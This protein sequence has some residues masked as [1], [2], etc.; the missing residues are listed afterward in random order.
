MTQVAV[1]GSL[2]RGMGNNYLLDQ[3]QFVGTTQTQEAYAMYSLGGFPKVVLG[4]SICP[5]IVEVYDV[6]DRGLARLD[7]LEG[8]RGNA[9]DS[10]YNRTEVPVVGLGTALIYHIENETVRRSLDVV[11]DGDWVRFLSER[12]E[13]KGY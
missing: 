10:F 11:E 12:R 1:Y 6:D 8:Y 5:I 2:R 3:Q 7:Q 9:A 13:Q 4:E